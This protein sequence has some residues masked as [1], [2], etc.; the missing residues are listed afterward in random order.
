MAEMER[1]E[2]PKPFRNSRGSV[3]RVRT[4]EQC[5]RKFKRKYVDKI[6]EDPGFAGVFGTVCHSALEGVY[7]WIVEEEYE[8]I[9]PKKVLLDEWN[10]AYEESF[11]SAMPEATFD[12]YSEGRQIMNQ[13]AEVTGEVDHSI[14]LENEGEFWFDLPGFDGCQMMGYIDRVDRPDEETVYVEDYKSN[15]LMFTKEQVESDLQATI[16]T[17]AIKLRYP[18]AKR[19]TFGFNMLR[20]GVTLTTERTEEQI[21][22]GLDYVAMM[23]RKT[24]NGESYPASV[25]TYCGY[26]SYQHDCDEFKRA[27]REGSL[28]LIDDSSIEEVARLRAVQANVAKDAY[29][30]KEELDK[31]LKAHFEVNGPFEAAGVSFKWIKTRKA[32]STKYPK[33]L[34]L[35]VMEKLGLGDREKLE[36][37]LLVVDP[38]KLGRYLS[39]TLKKREDMKPAEKRAV[40]EEVL[41]LAECG[42]TTRIDARAVKEYES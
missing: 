1:T 30:K 15:F 10:R 37:R 25:N 12:A 7:N 5:M 27:V 3:S 14:I 42:W 29:K 13:Y 26:C 36:K 21:K 11:I 8:G 35:E 16:Y 6:P 32:N 2:E 18:W 39:E 24:E 4:A 40:K 28:D 20:H 9:F 22:A 17:H 41:S 31:R 33:K 23:L 38:E 19:V 34:T